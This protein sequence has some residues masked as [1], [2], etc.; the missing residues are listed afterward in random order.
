MVSR[1]LGNV[2]IP[3]WRKREQVRVSKR[4][5]KVHQQPTR[6]NRRVLCVRVC[7][8]VLGVGVV[9]ASIKNGPERG[10]A[11][12]AKRGEEEGYGGVV[13]GDW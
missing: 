2:G 5:M 7:V 4:I 3:P 10:V 6:Y 9:A 1:K 8:G 13:I 11:S 12:E